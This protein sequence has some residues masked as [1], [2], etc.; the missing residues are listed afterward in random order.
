MVFSGRD[1]VRPDLIF[2][3]K[4]KMR[5]IFSIKNRGRKGRDKDIRIDFRDETGRNEISK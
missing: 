2:K 3:V 5:V 4:M 1:S